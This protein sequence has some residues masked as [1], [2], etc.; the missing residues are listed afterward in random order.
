MTGSLSIV[1]D[2]QILFADKIFS[3]FGYV[4]L[5]DGRS[6][7]NG[8]IKFDLENDII[9]GCLVTHEKKIIYEMTKNI[10]K[11]NT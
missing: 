4:N 10:I 3:K 11:G 6:I 9:K 8:K 7:D 5:V 2:D 1:A